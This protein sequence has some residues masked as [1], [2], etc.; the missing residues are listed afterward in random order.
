[1]QKEIRCKW[2]KFIAFFSRKNSR[3][4]YNRRLSLPPTIAMLFFIG[5]D[6]APE[7][8]YLIPIDIDHVHSLA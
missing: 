6:C 1:M 4:Y 5:S 8:K 3:M 7:Y 2:L